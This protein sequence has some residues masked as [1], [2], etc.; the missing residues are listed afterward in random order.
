[1]KKIKFRN[2][3]VY[4]RKDT[5]KK[6]IHLNIIMNQ[7]QLDRNFEMLE[8]DPE[9]KDYLMASQGQHFTML[10][11]A[12]RTYVTK[13]SGLKHPRPRTIMENSNPLSFVLKGQ[14]NFHNRNPV[15]DVFDA[16]LSG[17]NSGLVKIETEKRLRRENFEKLVIQ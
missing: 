1:M 11:K 8:R 16:R 9:F 12:I 14:Y 6:F 2:Q 15:S 17:T 5:L 7:N 4:D 3:N 13:D 10:P